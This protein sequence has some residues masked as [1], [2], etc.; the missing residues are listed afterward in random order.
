MMSEHPVTCAAERN[1]EAWDAEIQSLALASIRDDERREAAR[2]AG[3]R[4]LR[5]IHQGE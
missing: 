1:R 3:V 5:P 4:V 2:K